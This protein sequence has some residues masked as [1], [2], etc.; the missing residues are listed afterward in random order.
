MKSLFKKSKV[1][2]ANELLTD[3]DMILNIYDHI[4]A[5]AKFDCNG[6]LISYNLAFEKQFGYAIHEFNES[7]DKIFYEGN[8]NAI[9]NYFE[10]AL[11]GKT[12]KFSTVVK[13]KDGKRIDVHITLIPAEKCVF[14]IIR[15][16]TVF[17]KERKELNQLKRMLETLNKL[18]HICN[19]YY[20][21]INDIHYFSNQIFDL[22]KMNA[23][24]EQPTLSLNHYLRYVHPEDRE[25]VREATE[26]AIKEKR[27]FQIEYR[28]VQKDQSIILVQEQ[29]GIILDKKGNVEGLVGFIQ[30]ITDHNLMKDVLEKEKQL[31]EIYNNP[32]VGIWALDKRYNKT[33]KVSK[34]IECITGYTKEDF[35]NGLQW[36]SIVHE[37]DL[38]EYLKNLKALKEGN[39]VHHEYRIINKM[40]DRRWIQDYIIPN[41]DEHGDVI[42]LD[43]VIT[44]V[45]EKKVLEEKLKYMANYDLLTNLPNRK[46]FVAELEN[47]I[48]EYE[49]SKKQFAM[50]RLDIN[51][52]KFINNT[53]GNEIGD[54]ILKQLPKRLK[55]YL[56]PQDFVARTGGDEFI[57]LIK[58]IESID[59]LKEKI[60]QITNF[61]NDPFFVKEYQLYITVSIGACIFPENGTTSLELLR[62][63]SVALQKAVKE[64]KG[65]YHILSHTNS[66]QSYKNYSIGRDLKKAIENNELEFYIQPRVDSTTKQI[67]GAEALIRW[68][69]PKWGLL[70]PGEFISIAEENGLITDLDNWVIKGIIAKIREW[71]KYRIKT[72]PISINIS[73]I[74]FMKPDWPDFLAAEINKSGIDPND[75]ELEIT[76]NILLDNTVVVK[77]NL[78]KLKELGL[79]LVLDD[80][81][82]GYS[83]LSYITEYPFDA[84]KID[85]SFIRKI[86]KSPKNIHLLKTIL[87][88]AEGLK[89]KVVAEGV[90][91]A[92]QLKILQQEQCHEM[93]GYL[94]GKPVP[95]AEFET[96]VKKNI[97]LPFDGK[98]LQDRRKH[99]RFTFTDPLEAKLKISSIAKRNLDIGVSKVLVTE[100][101]AGGLRFI[102][103]LNLPIRMD[104]LYQFITELLGE[105]ILLNAKIVWKEEVN[106]DLA[107]YGVKFIFE[108]DEERTKFTTILDTF[109]TLAKNNKKVPCKR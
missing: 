22:L 60:K 4:D 46:N 100:I 68:R 35:D 55:Y 65:T 37:E 66:I 57:L 58:E 2:W 16:I 39:I 75:I 53:L 29:T 17:Q 25:M 96:V 13:T 12:Q 84:I 67:T 72:V 90:E 79:K 104:V 31:K 83:S 52:F 105:S 33:L 80:F 63:S 92:E 30:N 94:F 95:I 85:R 18:K 51:S 56:S 64:G 44:D 76:E 61:L 27:S 89:L 47:L 20:D 50:L 82:K 38:D 34:G 101:G 86:H 19:F 3:E 74:H 91:T 21:A 45:T 49:Q 32:D 88:L 23:R 41:L 70:L 43:R 8:S 81:G 5:I 10:K 71:K 62:N 93:Q 7:I 59:A 103:N 6:Q 108:N 1:R 42:R 14:A 99:H 77:K 98:G 109:V 78:N 97:P 40:G 24:H 102:S 87:Y 11:F 48:K 54:E 69:H 28:M 9:I 36:N 15:N 107:E 106:E 73:P 26:I